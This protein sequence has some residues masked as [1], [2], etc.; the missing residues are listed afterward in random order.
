MD[1][2][3]R[4]KPQTKAG[5]LGK[6]VGLLQKLQR[7][8]NRLAVIEPVMASDQGDKGL[9]MALFIQHTGAEA[10]VV[11]I[12]QRLQVIDTERLTARLRGP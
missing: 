2:F 4:F 6:Q 3:R 1:G 12:H 9:R 11:V 8:G 7:A 10:L 5:S